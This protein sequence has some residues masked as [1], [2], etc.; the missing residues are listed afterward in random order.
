MQDMKEITSQLQAWI[1][2]MQSEGRSLNMDDIN[3]HLA[4]MMS[5]RNASPLERFNEFSSHQMH[6]TKNQPF[7]EF[8]SKTADFFVPGGKG[9]VTREKGYNTLVI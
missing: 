5:A 3:A 1:D 6:L 2:R 4:E 9:I 8:F 7:S